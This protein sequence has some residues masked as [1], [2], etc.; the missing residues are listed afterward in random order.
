MLLLIVFVRSVCLFVCLFVCLCV[1]VYVLLPLSFWL[2]GSRSNLLAFVAAGGILVQAAYV[3]AMVSKE[4]K[5][6]P[7]DV[8]RLVNSK[9]EK[10]K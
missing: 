6:A 3:T 2:S 5:T 1:C 10:E 4:L 9:I 8:L 7:S